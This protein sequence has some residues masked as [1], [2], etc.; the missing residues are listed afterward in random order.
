MNIDLILNITEYLNFGLGTLLFLAYAYQ[1]FYII[2]ALIKKPKV[3]PAT[4]QSKRYAVMI[5]ARNERVC[6]PHLIES[7][8]A[9]TYPKDKIDIW[10]IADN[11]TDDTADIARSMG[12]HVVERQD[13]EHVGKG[14]ALNYL[15]HHIKKY[16]EAGYGAYAAYFVIDADNVLCADYIAEMDKAFSAGH[17]IVTSYRNSKNFKRNW[18]SAGYALWF[19]REAR[20][21]NH[22]R[23]VLNT[24][25]AI[26]GTG[27]MV[28]SDIIEKNDGWQCFLL[29]EDIEFT[30]ECVRK[31]ET[32]G[33]CHQAMLYDEQPITFSQSWRQ[34]KRWARGFFQ[35]MGKHGG[36]LVGGT[37]RGRFA[38]YDMMMTILPAFI[39]SL[40]ILAVNI[41]SIGL[42]IA[43]GHPEGILRVLAD[44]ALFLIWP[45]S[46]LFI[47]GLV[48]AI[49]ERK[50][51]FCST[52]KL[53]F[54][55]F[56]FPLFMLTY[57]PI[58]LS[59]MFGR[60]TWKPIVHTC[61]V[62]EAD[63]TGQC[64]SSSKGKVVP[65]G[66]GASAET[67]PKP[68]KHVACE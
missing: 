56:T 53:I 30:S 7:I 52:P 64:A 5:A 44:F 34:R 26:S 65:D 22:P 48:T 49:T 68:E 62:T 67:S 16:S 4:D 8:H 41:V 66:S 11:C 20:Y 31:G 33:Y 39:I 15:L 37:F 9:Q 25:A 2:V 18:I 36:G 63:I 19:L 29:T 17:R 42:C 14:Y 24:S 61:N 1:I 10:V 57:L 21:L 38:C 40:I 6:L 50:K 51:I 54:Y 12:A 13:P 3:Y 35:V 58:S 60:V 55:L 23:S 59:A 27:F 45:Y 32:I 47:M 28:A 46:I 43:V